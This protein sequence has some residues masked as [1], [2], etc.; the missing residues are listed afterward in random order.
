MLRISYSVP[1]D[2]TVLISFQQSDYAVNEADGDLKV[3]LIATNLAT[4]EFKGSINV[5]IRTSPPLSPEQRPATLFDSKFIHLHDS[6]S[7][8]LC[9]LCVY[10][11]FVF[12]F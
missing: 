5:T 12:L 8:L 4:L 1:V 2:P 9:L 10:L 6:E 7:E 11:I 3:T